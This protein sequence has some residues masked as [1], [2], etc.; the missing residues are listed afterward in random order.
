MNLIFKSEKFK[1]DYFSFLKNHLKNI[2]FKNIDRKIQNM[3]K[4][5]F[6]ILEKNKKKFYKEKKNFDLMKLYRKTVFEYFIKNNQCK[7]PWTIFEI[8]NSIT[9]IFENR[10]H[11]L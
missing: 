2:Y 9:T 7:I 3:I 8:E 11:Y 4:K 10:Y 6:K 5:L 1:K